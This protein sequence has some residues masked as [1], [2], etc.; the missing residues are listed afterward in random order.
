MTIACT[1]LAAEVER[2]LAQPL[3]RPHRG[4]ERLTRADAL[5]ARQA[6][7]SRLRSQS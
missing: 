4:A 3:G 1:G 6:A 2:D 7:S 5:G